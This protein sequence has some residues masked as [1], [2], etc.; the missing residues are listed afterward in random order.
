MY[1]HFIP[2]TSS[3][4]PIQGKTAA[5]KARAPAKKKAPTKE[6]TDEWSWSHAIPDTLGALGRILSRVRTERIWQ[7]TSE[8]DTFISCII[9]SANQVAES[10]VYMKVVEVRQQVYKIFCLAA[11]NHGQAFGVQTSITQNLQYFEHLS[12]PMAELV[13][14]LAKEFD[15]AQCGDEILRTIANKS[16]IDKGDSKAESK[17]AKSFARFM[18]KLT[19]LSPRLVLKQI[20]L[21]QRQLD[22]ESYQIRNAIVEVIGILIKDLLNESPVEDDSQGLGANGVGEEQDRQR[23]QAK[24]IQA[25]FDLLFERFLDLN[26]HVRAKTVTTLIKL[27]E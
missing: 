1:L 26:S 17:D 18:V 7:T 9:A 25:F 3:N 13:S 8:R 15:Y 6:R 24:Q 4:V 22:S 14:I 12:E 11:K 20:S 10:D 23:T 21:L 16:F 5:S 2:K 19:E 27:M